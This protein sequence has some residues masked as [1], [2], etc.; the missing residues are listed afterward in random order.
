MLP[1]VQAA[2]QFAASGAGRRAVICSL[3]RAPEAMQGRSGTVVR[4]AEVGAAVAGAAV[5]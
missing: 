4:A 2:A 3:D 5:A 1:K